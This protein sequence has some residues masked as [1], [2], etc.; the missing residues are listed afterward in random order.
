M[1]SSVGDDRYRSNCRFVEGD[2]RDSALC[3]TL[4]QDVDFVLHQAALC[5]VPL[6]LEQ[7]LQTH[8]T[9][10]TASLNLMWASV[11]ARVKRFVY[12]SSCAVYGD[13]RSLPHREELTGHAL[14]P[15][16]VGK[17]AT[18]LYAANFFESHE[19]PTVGLRYFNIFGPRQSADGA[20]AAVIP[21]FVRDILGGKQVR[22]NGD[23][24]TSRDFCFVD[25]VV[26]A[27]L[28]AARQAR[29]E[30]FGNVFNVAS[31]DQLSIL[32]L[33]REIADYLA[34]R[35]PGINILDPR[36]EDF[37]P[38][39]IRHSRGDISRISQSLG[40]RPA[41]SVRE[42]LWTT[43]DWYMENGATRATG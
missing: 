15:Y 40:Y 10:V 20:Y 5:S 2:L 41:P 1:R 38:G 19:L 35:Q 27:N 21:S 18:E 42:G 11:H 30:C 24:K 17:F 22:I 7:P 23:G 6:S 39:E 26:Q 32:E 12:A 33:Y 34:Q 9:N 37:R 16:A 4:C 43:L 13:Q 8:D 36:F 14:S 25:N 29:E 3:E 31:G 28:L